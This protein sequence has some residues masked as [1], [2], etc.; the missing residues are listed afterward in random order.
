MNCEAMAQ[1]IFLPRSILPK[2][3]LRTFADAFRILISRL[4][5][6]VVIVYTWFNTKW[7][8][9]GLYELHIRKIPYFAICRTDR[10]SGGFSVMDREWLGQ[11]KSNGMWL[12]YKLVII[13]IS[14]SS[15]HCCYNC[16]DTLMMNN[17]LGSALLYLRH[18]GK[19]RP[20]SMGTF[21]HI[22]TGNPIMKKDGLISFLSL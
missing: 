8:T 6:A 15:F 12:A 19:L 4:L 18:S 3:P 21:C 7:E 16:A 17:I 5:Q 2:R 22:N 13:T 9:T 14:V 11:L 10:A 20:V 1:R